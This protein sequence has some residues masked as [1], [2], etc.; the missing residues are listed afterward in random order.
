MFLR[1]SARLHGFAYQRATLRFPPGAPLDTISFLS[2]ML[3]RDPQLRLGSD[4]CVGSGGGSN[5][6]DGS[7][8]G[9]GFGSNG[10]TAIGELRNA[11]IPPREIATC[12]VKYRN[13]CGGYALLVRLSV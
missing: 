7:V 11:S 10:F 9:G 3:D 6:S 5:G 12:L 2:K 4:V 8:G 1:A 13:S